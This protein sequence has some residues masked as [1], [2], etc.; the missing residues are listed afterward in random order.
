MSANES[1]VVP[2]ETVR[3]TLAAVN[4]QTRPA[5]D[6]V[7]CVGVPPGFSLVSAP[8]ARLVD[9][10]PCRTIARLGPMSVATLAVHLRLNTRAGGAA[11]VRLPL[12]LSVGSVRAPLA[13]LALRVS[14]GSAPVSSPAGAPP[15]TG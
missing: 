7:L 2:G 10:A 13:Q 4:P 6:V 14:A 8:G 12:L 3:L 11:R 15:V 9:G 1:S 5:E